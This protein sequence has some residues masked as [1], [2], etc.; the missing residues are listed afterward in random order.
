MEDI[1][2]QEQLA[3]Q[4]G[5]DRMGEGSAGVS[6]SKKPGSKAQ[7]RKRT[8]TGCLSELAPF[9]HAYDLAWL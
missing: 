9:L 2:P 8:K 3:R 6:E 1:S 5:P 7:G 4:E